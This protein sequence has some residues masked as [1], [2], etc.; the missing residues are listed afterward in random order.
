MRKSRNNIDRFSLWKVKPHGIAVDDYRREQLTTMLNQAAHYFGLKERELLVLPK[1]MTFAEAVKYCG[2]QIGIKA[3][4]H[5]ENELMLPLIARDKKR[6][7]AVLLLPHHNVY[8][9]MSDDA[10][11]I[12]ASECQQ[13]FDEMIEL[14]PFSKPFAHLEILLRTLLSFV[15]RIAIGVL[16][17]LLALF[18]IAFIFACFFLQTELGEVNRDIIVV[19]ALSMALAMVVLLKAADAIVTKNYG[20]CAAWLFDNVYRRYLQNSESLLARTSVHDVEFLIANVHQCLKRWFIITPRLILVL[21]YIGLATLV[22]FGQSTVLGLSFLVING[23]VILSV[24]ILRQNAFG[25]RR[26]WQ[27]ARTDLFHTLDFYQS[28]R[29]QLF[30]L[31]LSERAS[32]HL[33]RAYEQAYRAKE[34]AQQTLIMDAV[35]FLVPC[36]LFLSASVVM[37]LASPTIDLLPAMLTIVL[38]LSYALVFVGE[39]AH[40]AMGFGFDASVMNEINSWPKQSTHAHVEPVQQEGAIELASIS[41]G[42]EGN[43]YPI[44]RDFSLTID[45]K[46]Y[47]LITGP[48]GSGKTT[49]LKILAGLNHPH[50]GEILFDGQDVRAL[51]QT[52]LRNSFGVVFDHADIFVGSIYHNILCGRSL[53]D[54]AVKRLLLSHEVF[55]AL[56][57]LPMA[58]ETYIIERG[59]NISRLE[60]C[61]IL[62]ARALVHQPKF[63]FLDEIFSGLSL[64]DQIVVGDFLSGL[65]ITRII[66]TQAA[67][68]FIK[69]NKTV[70]LPTPSSRVL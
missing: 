24:W 20:L 1:I 32:L 51:N 46:D 53:A 52:T 69:S 21:A 39:K 70:L 47:V 5:R 38:V 57:D 40:D 66:T 36:G 65:A 25:K 27:I 12:T 59:K 58:L 17:V 22:L 62:L 54:D 31:D 55:D 23:G 33:A 19:G 3:V 35:Y 34:D 6:D 29:S 37:S 7:D 64:R 56:L 41:F 26:L 2:Q 4:V 49:L 48:S 10:E 63:L 18:F 30:G 60:R 15:P 67:L 14:R 68:T 11:R 61:A 50:R 13:R 8:V 43:P 42:Y 28:S 16:S 9:V 44:F 45:A